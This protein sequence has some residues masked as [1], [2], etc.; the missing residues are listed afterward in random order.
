MHRA[1]LDGGKVGQW[2]DALVD[3][4]ALAKE[5]A[6]GVAIDLDLAMEDEE[7]DQDQEGD[8]GEIDPFGGSELS[9]PPDVDDDNA[10]EK[11][12]PKSEE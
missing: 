11:A 10:E 3:D 2:D 8:E 6:G 4:E 5:R 12:E 1:W 7:Q 9:D